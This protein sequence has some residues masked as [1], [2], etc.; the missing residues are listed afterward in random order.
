[1]LGVRLEIMEEGEHEL[2]LVEP[3]L[4]LVEETPLQVQMQL[5]E[6]MQG[7]EVLAAGE[8]LEEMVERVGVIP[9]LLL[10]ILIMLLPLN[11]EQME[12]SVEREVMEAVAEEGVKGGGF[13]TA[14][15]EQEVQE[16]LAVLEEGVEAAEMLGLLRV[17][18]EEKVMVVMVQQE[19]MAEVEGAVVIAIIVVVVLV[20]AA[21]AVLD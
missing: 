14:L 9:P 7:M 19:G 2:C 17:L 16:V 15:Q 18:M 8:V 3:L 10:Q 6:E 11:Q 13:L 12:V 20:A 21:L 4:G 1:M 5:M